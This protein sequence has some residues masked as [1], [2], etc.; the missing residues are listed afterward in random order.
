MFFSFFNFCPVK[1]YFNSL[2][3]KF[4]PHLLFSWL[5]HWVGNNVKGGIKVVC[6]DLFF[7][8]VSNDSNYKKYVYLK[9]NSEMGCKYNQ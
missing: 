2:E 5:I 9:A 7:N 6:T 1:I 8:I 4:L 3:D